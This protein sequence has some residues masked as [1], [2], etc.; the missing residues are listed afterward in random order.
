MKRL[1]L[2]LCLLIPNVAFAAAEGAIAVMPFK[3][4]NNEQSLEWLKAGV[5]ETMISD[6]RK[7]GKPVV[8]RDQ[9]DKAM[10]E[11]ALQGVKGTEDSQAAKLGK[12]VGAKTVVVGGFQKAGK[13]V[14]ITAR[15]VVVET[16]VVQETAKATGP[17][18]NIFAL[19]DEIVDTLLGVKPGAKSNGTA[20]AKATP[21]PKPKRKNDAK[22]VE[23]YK[24]YA[25][26]LTVASDA[27]KVGY[28]KKSIEIDPDFAYAAEDLEKLEQRMGIY[29]KAADTALS[30]QARALR[31]TLEDPNV[32]G[33]EK[34]Q[35]AIALLGSHMSNFRWKAVIEDAKWIHSLDLPKLSYNGTIT[36]DPRE[37]AT[38]YL[39]TAHQSL[40]QY[41][42]A[43]QVGERFMS[44]YPGSS[45]FMGVEMQMTNIMQQKRYRE[46]KRAE[47]P[48]LIEEH[49]AEKAKAIADAEKRSQ[50]LH[51]ARALSFDTFLC[52]TYSRNYDSEKAIVECRKFLDKYKGTSDEQAKQMSLY[53]TLNL[54]GAYE[55]LGD[56][57]NAKKLVEGLKKDEPSFYNQ[58]GI[59][60]RLSTYPK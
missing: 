33:E 14:R 3:N 36:Q 30:E 41:D 44:Q 58:N 60:Y 8:E 34:S 24:L 9:L 50:P 54:I 29:R 52:T 20:I 37:Y 6:L 39:F 49:E 40:K 55:E 45:M 25:M 28:L 18:T 17:L 35:K 42:Q 57:E 11:L 59:A 19:Q 13:D 12:M 16:G 31:K 1:L 48:K 43:L 2:V 56:F 32:P 5:A 26:S 53:M 51:P 15:F 46:E 23:A 22:T 21:R 47:I 38:F 4:L 27:E 10:A 7:A